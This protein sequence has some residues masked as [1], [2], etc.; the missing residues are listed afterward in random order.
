MVNIFE[1][2]VC[3][4]ESWCVDYSDDMAFHLGLEKVWPNILCWTV[5]TNVGPAGKLRSSL[6][7]L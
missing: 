1:S 6:D 4:I 7:E 5:C 3:I 2:S